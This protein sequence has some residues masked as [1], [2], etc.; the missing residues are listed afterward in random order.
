MQFDDSLSLSEENMPFVVAP[1][2]FN[3]HI[4]EATNPIA[5]HY[6]H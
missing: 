1:R 3:A 5:R 4:A 2:T 6:T